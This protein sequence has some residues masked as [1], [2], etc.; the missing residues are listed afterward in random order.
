MKYETNCNPLSRGKEREDPGNK[1][2]SQH[3]ARKWKS[4]MSL[5][6]LDK[7]EKQMK[8]D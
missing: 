4:N 3:D 5:I 8:Y 2:E 6:F 1:L 7:L